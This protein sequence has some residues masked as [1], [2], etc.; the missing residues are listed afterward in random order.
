MP[1]DCFDKYIAI[2]LHFTLIAP[3][4]ASIN[5]LSTSTDAIN[6]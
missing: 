3:R 5:R 4:K 1:V 2:M 6:Q